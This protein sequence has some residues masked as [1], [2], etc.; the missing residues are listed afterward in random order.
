VFWLS[1][2]VQPTD[3]EDLAT[4][5]M[6]RAL[7]AFDPARGKFKA[8]LGKTAW[9]LLNGWRRKEKRWLVSL[10]EDTDVEDH[11]GPP[12]PVEPDEAP[13]VGEDEL[14]EVANSPLGAACLDCLAQLR[15]GDGDVLRLR[16]AGTPFELIAEILETPPGTCA[17]RSFRA[18]RAVRRCLES[19]GF[20]FVPRGQ[21]RPAGEVLVA[22]RDV[23]VIH[24]GPSAR[25][26]VR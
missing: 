15:D 20:L 18:R 23:L 26:D 12:P 7:R 1:G 10:G 6:F 3:A 4:E 14:A 19:K 16:M 2:Y 25:E 11:I 8:L 5:A 21:T 13:V 9:N 24:V 22:Y 17:S